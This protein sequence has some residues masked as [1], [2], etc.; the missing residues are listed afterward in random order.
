MLCH[1]PHSLQFSFKLFNRFLRLLLLQG[2]SIPKF[3]SRSSSAA[4][5]AARAAVTSALDRPA[6]GSV[7]IRSE[8]TDMVADITMVAN[9]RRIYNP[10]R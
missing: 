6:L 3:L 1:L 4:F 8:L 7:M 5:F 10:T 2:A 9:M